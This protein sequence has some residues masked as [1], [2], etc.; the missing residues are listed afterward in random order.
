MS[1]DNEAWLSDLRGRGVQRD[2]AISALRG[3]LLGNLRKAMSDRPRADDA[4]LEDAAQDA[5]V[6]IL[7]R[8]DQ[9]LG[10]S[11]FLTWATAIAIRVAMTELRRRNWRDVSLEDVLGSPQG[12]PEPVADRNLGPADRAERSAIL[13][14]LQEAIATGLTDKQRTALLAELNGMPLAEIAR[15]LGS[16]RNAVYK[17]TYDARKKLKQALEAAGYRAED[18]QAAFAE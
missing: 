17:L 1:R 13:A 4:F 2:A 14:A 6:R 10:R 15:L 3:A 18:I 9:F 7:D 8:L 16:N 12:P 11:R 5:L